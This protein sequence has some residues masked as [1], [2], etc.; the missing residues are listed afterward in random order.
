[1]LDYLLQYIRSKGGRKLV[2]DATVVYSRD[3]NLRPNYF[4]I[5]SLHLHAL[6]ARHLRHGIRKVWET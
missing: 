6:E 3:L 1:M 5:V 2:L 4:S